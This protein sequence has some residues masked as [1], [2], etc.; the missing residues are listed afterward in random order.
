MT[1]GGG[2]LAGRVALVTGAG[3]GIGRACALRLA[4][5]GAHVV[6][7]DV[8]GE[9]VEK[10]AAEVGGTPV[11]VDL[12]EPGFLG[13]LRDQVARSPVTPGWTAASPPDEIR[14]FPDVVVSSAGFLGEPE[15]EAALEAF[16]R[17]LKVLVGAPYQLVRAALP[18][19][20]EQRWGRVITI[21]DIPGGRAHAATY[22]TARH[23][24]ESLTTAVALEGAPYGVT[25][26]CVTPS[27]ARPEHVAETVADLCAR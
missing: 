11:M 17:I 25:A 16:A 22:A 24:L 13:A 26:A 10:V 3:S 9:T 2:V 23:A 14:I 15:E 21:A 1:S 4:A 18:Y 27:H 5:A 12:S 7:V 20:K 8:V 19:M 6:V